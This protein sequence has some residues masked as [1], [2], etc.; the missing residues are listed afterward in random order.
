MTFEVPK[1]NNIIETTI[2]SEMKRSYIDYS[3]SVIVSRA[4]PDVRD[5]LK[6][7]QR[8]ILHAMNELGLH[9]NKK[10]N[11]CARIVGEVMG[12]FHPHGDSSIYGALV[13]MAQDF[14]LRYPLINGQGNFGNVDF[15]PASMRYTEAKMQKLTDEMLLDIGKDTVNFVPNY[16]DNFMEPEVLPAR[17]PNLLINGAQG[18]A[19]GLA[20]SIPPHN[21]SEV[22]DGVLA[23]LDNP[24]IGISPSQVGSDEEKGLMDYI[25]A[26]DFPTNGIIYGYTGIKSMYETGRGR[27]VLRG[28][29]EYIEAK[30]KGQRNTIVITELPYQVS[31]KGL[32]DKIVD[33]SKD[34]RIDGIFDVVDESSRETRI[35]IELKKDA[36]PEVLIN[37]LYKFTPLQTSI[38]GNFIALVNNKPVQLNLKQ[39]LEQFI[40]H[41]EDVIVRRTEFDLKK[42]KDRI[43]ILEG[44]KKALDNIDRIIEIIRG[45]RT[46]DDAKKSLIE[47]FDF[48]EI[49]AAAILAMRL[50]QLTGLEREKLEA[51]ISE[52][53]IK[54][55]DLED[56]LARRERRIDIIRE[57]SQDI[58][59]RFGDERRSEII[60][61]A[62]DM[63]VEELIPD[64]EMVITISHQGYIKRVGSS[65]YKSQGR[66]GVGSKGAAS[67]D[68]DFIQ[69]LIS[70]KNHDYIMVF[71]EDGRVY[72]KKV[73]EIPETSK[74]S[75]GRPIVNLIE[76]THGV[77]VR[78]IL[79][80]RDFEKDGKYLVMATKNGI[81]KKTA[82][83]AYSRP[84]RGGIIAIN[85]REGDELLD[86][87]ITNDNDEIIL[88]TNSGYA[89]RFTEKDARE[90]GRNSIG[91][92]GIDLREGDYV[93]GMVISSSEETPI[94]VVSK[95]GY[96]K[97]TEVGEYRKT[98]RGSKGVKS[99]NITEKTGE[100]I[101][102]SKA[103]DGNDIMIMTVNGIAIR[104]SVNNVRIMGRNTQGVRLITLRDNDN[105]GDICVVPEIEE[106][107]ELPDEVTT[108]TVEVASEISEPLEGSKGD[109]EESKPETSDN[110]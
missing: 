77:E 109:D 8:R 31:R 35:V 7:V 94:L 25:K 81:I 84:N 19:V 41:R 75:K 100:M 95:N 43:H 39:Y 58:K 110:E 13:R 80:V 18:I 99:M 46:T 40:L 63:T 29:V 91:V 45:S 57:E 87:Q 98:K 6:P 60:Y 73:W 105:I 107:E 9:Y 1:D 20:T 44:L 49:Q 86:V 78:S 21:I 108:E 88:G 68:S 71:T 96:G 89:N 93:V 48:T 76:K 61:Q 54:I 26:P 82:L 53:I 47:E 56:I 50:S 79:I 4:L 38:S 11:K 72:W 92:K 16:D 33:L 2:E 85:L 30:R 24:D 36:N 65:E 51:E 103:E 102:I 3:M 70:A 74:T 42:A 22:M 62:D 27:V 55:E 83:M 106:K 90:V 14:S 12:K 69:H 28:K 15:G 10:E 66:G 23:L 32:I 5:G 67:K 101:A 52:L 37:K 17:L 64:D 97:R 104:Q 59:E 34:K